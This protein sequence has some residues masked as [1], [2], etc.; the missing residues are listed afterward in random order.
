MYDST[1]PLTL[2]NIATLPLLFR[3][4]IKPNIFHLGLLLIL[5]ATAHADHDTG[6][7]AKNMKGGL[8]AVEQRLWNCENGIAGA[9]PG[10]PGAMGPQGPEGP[11]GPQGPTG[12]QGVAGADGAIGPQGPAGP[13]GPEGPEGPQGPA[14]DG[15]PEDIAALHNR[16]DNLELLVSQQFNALQALLACIDPSSNANE[17]IFSGCNV[18]IRNG[19]NT[20]DSANM[21]GNLIIGYNEGFGSRTGSHNLIIGPNHDYNGT[22]GIIAGNANQGMIRLEGDTVTLGEGLSTITVDDDINIES[23]RDI[24]MNANFGLDLKAGVSADM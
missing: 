6:H 17:M 7:V 19:D 2:K 21:A 10:T 1:S 22:S 11:V 5:S 18:N 13:Q 3:F 16:I 9:C 4:F 23:Q 20:S 14:G 8:R 15:N 12:P 24:T